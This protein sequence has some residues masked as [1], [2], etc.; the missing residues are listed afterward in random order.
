MLIDTINTST[1]MQ[2]TS[3]SAGEMVTSFPC[4]ARPIKYS[5]PPAALV[6]WEGVVES[7]RMKSYA[8]DDE[9]EEVESAL[10]SIIPDSYHT[11][12]ALAR[13]SF[14]PKEKGGRNVLRYQ[15]LGDHR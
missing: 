13:L 1:A 10:T 15:I 12:N 2:E 8:S 6:T 4:T 5:P 14:M 9:L 7:S 11:C 3:D